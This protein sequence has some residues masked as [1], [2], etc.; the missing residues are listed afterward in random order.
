M[1]KA[2]QAAHTGYGITENDS[3]LIML[4][5]NKVVSV[6]ILLFLLASNCLFN[7][8]IWHSLALLGVISQINDLGILGSES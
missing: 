2:S 5:F 8:C 7:K 3:G 1:K 4:L 6:K